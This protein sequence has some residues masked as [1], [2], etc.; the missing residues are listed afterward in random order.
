MIKYSMFFLMLL[1][2]SYSALALNKTGSSVALQESA[3]IEMGLTSSKNKIFGQTHFILE[4]SPALEE[5]LHQVTVAMY[6]TDNWI[7]TVDSSRPGLQN[8][9]RYRYNQDVIKKMKVMIVFRSGEK[10]EITYDATTL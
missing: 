9:Y 10:F 8:R 5:K 4:V 1:S 6:S 3:A 2:F 7:T